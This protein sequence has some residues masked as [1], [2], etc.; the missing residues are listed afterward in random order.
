MRPTSP[1]SCLDS[2]K[3]TSEL[4]RP[5]PV[6]LRQRSSA[7]CECSH[8]PSLLTRVWNQQE[9]SSSELVSQPCP[10]L[11]VD[12]NLSRIW[13]GKPR[14][15]S[16]P[17]VSCSGPSDPSLVPGPPGRTGELISLDVSVVDVWAELLVCP[18]SRWVCGRSFWP[19]S[20]LSWC[21]VVLRPAASAQIPE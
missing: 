11:R 19:T 6:R 10:L 14:P 18:L 5:V 12:P 8:T 15:V 3:R 21:C 20:C 7:R 9:T 1:N 13:T 4:S 17:A 16:M 2:E